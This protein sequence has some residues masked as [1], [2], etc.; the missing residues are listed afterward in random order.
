MI[1]NTLYYPAADTAI[2][3][4]QFGRRSRPQRC[5]ILKEYI[6]GQ[7]DAGQRLDRFVAKTV[8]LLP[9][10]LA[11]KYIRLKRI[12]VGGKGST[13]DYKLSIGDIVQM[14]INDEFFETPDKNNAYLKINSPSLDI[15]YEDR[16]I[17]LVNK[18]A[19]ILCHSNDI[20]DN[21]SIITKT[22]AYLYNKG[23]WLPHDENAFS[24]AL[25]NRIDR[26]T[27]GIIL[28]AK[29]AESLRILNERIKLREIDKYY[30]TVV[31]GAPDPP[32]GKIENNVFKDSVKN[33]VFITDKKSPGTKTASTE[34]KTI[35]TAGD[36][37]LL[38]CRL[39]TGRTHQIRAQLANI[40]APLLGDGKY[41]NDRLNKKY[42]EKRQALCSYKLVFSFKTDAGSLQYLNKKSFELSSVP[43]VEKYFPLQRSAKSINESNSH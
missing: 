33:M 14:Y 6:I 21:S 34:Y 39:I 16:N 15:I 1:A 28:T 35:A 32:S 31:H 18:P 10:S 19:G 4:S 13:R 36:L 42:S 11:Q 8:P 43:F 37:S 22:Q 12:K 41:G 9:G 38:E 2:L 7:N 23:E 25:C 20:C 26:N 29:N 24:P 40:G 5:W 3:N 17:L 30:L 27:S